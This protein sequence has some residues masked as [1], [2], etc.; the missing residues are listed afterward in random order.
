MADGLSAKAPVFQGGL[1]ASVGDG[2]PPPNP[3]QPNLSQTRARPAA[4]THS[5]EVWAAQPLDVQARAAHLPRASRQLNKP[6]P[7]GRGFVLTR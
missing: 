3:A 1:P 4:G 6:R 2:A 5:L 7:E